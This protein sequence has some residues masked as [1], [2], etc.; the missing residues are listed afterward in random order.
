VYLRD[1]G[2]IVQNFSDCL[3]LIQS[4]PR[5]KQFTAKGKN[6]QGDL[7]FACVHVT[8]TNTCGVYTS[9]PRLCKTYP[10]ISMLRFGAIPKPDCGFCFV[11]RFTGKKV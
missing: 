10:H 4:D 11:N 7:Y 8:R 6:E 9:R 3:S 5:M 1:R 2:K